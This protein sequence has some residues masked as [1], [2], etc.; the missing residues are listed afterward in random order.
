LDEF[1]P[2]AER[3]GEDGT[4]TARRSWQPPVLTRLGASATAAGYGPGE[5]GEL[6]GQQSL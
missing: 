4:A 5:D 6:T 1:V 3:A 2:E